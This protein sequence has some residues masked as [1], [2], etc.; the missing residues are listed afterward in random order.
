[1]FADRH[2]LPH[3]E[4]GSWPVTYLATATDNHLA[5]GT[6]MGAID[7]FQENSPLSATTCSI[8]LPTVFEGLR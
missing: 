3:L 5:L 6:S 7:I 8:R 2:N 4:Q 1:M